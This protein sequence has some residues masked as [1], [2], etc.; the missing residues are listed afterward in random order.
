MLKIHRQP[1]FVDCKRFLRSF[2][3]TADGRFIE[4]GR[5]IEDFLQC[6]A[7]FTEFVHGLRSG[8]SLVDSLLVFF[9]ELVGHVSALVHL[10]ALYG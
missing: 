6:L 5:F 4:A 3:Q 9:G 2:Q 10:T 7:G 1:D 8:K